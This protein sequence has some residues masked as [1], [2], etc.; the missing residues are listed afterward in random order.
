MK[1]RES[2]F[3]WNI[4]N[5]RDSQKNTENHRIV[6]KSISI[7]Q[8]VARS[9][10][11]QQETNQKP[12]NLQRTKNRNIWFTMRASKMVRRLCDPHEGQATAT[13]TWIN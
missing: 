7:S 5:G 12:T 11:Q 3:N 6:P 4:C 8:D 1:S 2:N 13:G 10:C 9:I